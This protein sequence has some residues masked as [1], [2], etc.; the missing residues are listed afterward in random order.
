MSIGGES[1][2]RLFAALNPRRTMLGRTA[3]Q[4]RSSPSVAPASIIIVLIIMVTVVTTTVGYAALNPASTPASSPASSPASCQRHN[5]AAI[6]LTDRQSGAIA[7]GTQVSINVDWS[8]YGPVVASN[9]QNVQFLDSA[10]VPMPAWLESCDGSESSCNSSSNSSLVWVKLDQSIQP[11]GEIRMFLA[12]APTS[13]NDFS[14]TGDWGESPQLSPTYAEFDNG[15][16]VFNFY[17]DFAGTSLGSQWNIGA[18]GNPVTVDNGLTV[19]PAQSENDADAIST[20]SSFGEGAID[21][22]GVIPATA[23]LTG[24]FTYAGVGIGTAES[25]VSG[26]C[27]FDNSVLIGEA[28]GTYGLETGSSDGL[29]EGPGSIVAGLIFGTNSTYSILI[30]SSSPSTVTASVNYGQNISSSTGLPTLPQPIAIFNQKNTGI[31][32]GPVYWI[33]E[34]TY[35]EPGAVTQVI[36]TVLG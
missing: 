10:G 3:S 6:T 23:A 27:Y 31:S 21:F 35:T 28:T 2:E 7:S 5:C 8:S 30:P 26:C 25:T 19:G 9:L 33:R 29:D 22:Y 13:T 15:A 14:P 20:G 18:G 11:G 16:R 24:D 1:V 36:S 12:F 4:I 17:D 34:R 32:I